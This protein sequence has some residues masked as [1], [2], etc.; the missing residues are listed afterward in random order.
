MQ[1]IKKQTIN[2]KLKIFES[3]KLLATTDPQIIKNEIS[4]K[5]NI[6]LSPKELQ[7]LNK[8]MNIYKS[9]LLLL[10]KGYFIQ[11][12]A[13]ELGLSTS[14]IQRYLND[15]IIEEELGEDVKQE[16]KEKLEKNLNRGKKKGGEE[17]SNNNVA[18]K[19]EDGKFIGSYPR[20]I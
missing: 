6:E 20:V 7:S 15:P 4:E 8:K 13:N 18:A 19:G 9:V 11:Q 14:C 5:I 12:I 16:I 3:I 1:E 10:T 17:Y 2:E